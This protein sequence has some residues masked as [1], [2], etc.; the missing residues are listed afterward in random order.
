[1]ELKSDNFFI[2]GFSY[3]NTS[4]SSRSVLAT[5]ASDVTSFLKRI[6]VA[7]NLDEVILISTCNR[8]EI[9]GF[10]SPRN[11]TIDQVVTEIVKFLQEQVG[12]K[13]IVENEQYFTILGI[14][15][16]RYLA[17]VSA[18]ID[19]MVQGEA[20]IFGQ[21]KQCYNQAFI[22][23][24]VGRFLHHVF[25]S[26][27]KTTKSIRTNTHLGQESLSVASISIKLIEQF[28][29]SFTDLNVIV[30]GS[31]EIAELTLLHLTQR[32]AENITILNRTLA[33]ADNLAR[34]FNLRAG[35]L[36]SL[37]EMLNVAD[38]I[39]GSLKIEKPI[40]SMN[41]LKNLRRNRPLVF[42]D[43]GVPRNFQSSI[44]EIDDLF[45]YDIESLESIAKKHKATREAAVK[46]AELIIDYN[47]HQFEVWLDCLKH[48][49]WK[50][51]LRE[52]LKE[53]CKDEASKLF[54]DDK[55]QELANKFAHRVSKKF[56]NEFESIFEDVNLCSNSEMYKLAKKDICKC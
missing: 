46:D 14:E 54:S 53:I 21:I 29:S 13:I 24:T 49:P 41:Q 55:Q 37:P 36:S 35:A 11:K 39:I 27:F 31:G 34:R 20:Q 16:Y 23:G 56:A 6:K 44:S 28:Y 50:I 4:L 43:L 47:V 26:I 9:V 48:E 18:S 40:L 12:E 1:M 51:N 22:A 19:S 3:H 17:N 42:I 33:N 15:A 32:G 2:F 25:Q 38:V 52:T 45:C 10:S 30:L 5:T 8:F 7:A